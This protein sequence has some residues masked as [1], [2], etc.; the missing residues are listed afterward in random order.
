MNLKCVTHSYAYLYY[1]SHFNDL[2]SCSKSFPQSLVWYYCIFPSQKFLK[3]DKYA[4][5]MLDL[6]FSS[7]IIQTIPDTLKSIVN[8]FISSSPQTREPH[9]PLIFKS[10]YITIILR[11]V[12]KAW[13]QKNV[14][15]DNF[16]FIISQLKLHPILK[17]LVSTPHD[18][19]LIMG[20]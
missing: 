13:I 14:N 8:F 12:S 18:Y 17:I 2:Y 11:F 9:R 15:F 6:F 10:R 3:S 4:L 20:G 7:V 5:R 1:K 19:S 16:I